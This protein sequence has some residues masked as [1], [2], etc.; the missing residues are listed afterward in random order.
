MDGVEDME[1]YPCLIRATDG[2]DNKISTLV[3]PA[4]QEKFLTEYGNICKVQMDTLKKKD[5]KDRK[6]KVIGKKITKRPTKDPSK[7]AKSAA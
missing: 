4:D 1:E 2:Y 7:K 5:R 6:R 3:Q